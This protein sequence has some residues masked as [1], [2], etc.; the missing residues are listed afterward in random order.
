M[1]WSNQNTIASGTLIYIDIYNIDQ[2]KAA[3]ITASQYISVTV[4]SDNNYD[5]G[6]LA[7]A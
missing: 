6:V 5:N 1:V 4:D 2:P 3:D 7:S